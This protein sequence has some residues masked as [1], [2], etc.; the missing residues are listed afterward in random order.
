MTTTTSG[1]VCLRESDIRTLLSMLD[2]VEVN[3]GRCVVHGIVNGD[4]AE[5]ITNNIMSDI[6]LCVVHRWAE[7]YFPEAFKGM[8]PEDSTFPDDDEF[9]AAYEAAGF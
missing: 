3:V 1:T 6:R 5:T 8:N 7:K 2:E 9:A 4:D